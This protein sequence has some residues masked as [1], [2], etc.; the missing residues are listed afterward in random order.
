MAA[1]VAVAAATLDLQQFAG[2]GVVFQ[3]QDAPVGGDRLDLVDDAVVLLVQFHVEDV[4]GK[5]RAR[6]RDDG[7]Q[8]QDAP[9]AQRR[10]RAVVV[11]V[12]PRGLKNGVVE[13]KRR[14]TGEREELSAESALAKLAR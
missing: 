4:A 1:M 14:A 13:L 11:V 12:G 8:R 2:R 7:L 9:L 5:V 10:A 3:L 6:L